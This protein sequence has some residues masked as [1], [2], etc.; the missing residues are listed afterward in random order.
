MGTGYVT[1][2]HEIA[3]PGRRAPLAVLGLALAA[4]LAYWLFATPDYVPVSDAAHYFEIAANLANGDGFAHTFPQLEL[5]ATAFR[6]P[7]YPGILAGLFVVTGSSIVAGRLLNLALG[8]VVVALVMTLGREVGGRPA[9]LAAGVA[10]AV[11]PPLVFNDLV[12]LTES[13]SLVLVLGAAL[14]LLRE[15]WVLAGVAVGLLVLSRTSA[16]VLV[17]V[18]AAW[19]FYRVGWRHAARFSLAALV[20]VAPWLVRNELQ[21]DHLGL[22]TSNGFNLAAMYSVEAQDVGA[23][24]DPVFHPGFEDL[25]LL[26]FDEAAWSEELAE[27]GLDGLRE[28]PRYIA[29][30]IGRNAAAFFE[31]KPSFNRFAEIQD[32][33]HLGV[34]GATSWLVPVVAIAGSVGLWRSRRHPG[35]QLAIIFAAYFVVVSLLTIAAP[36]LRSPADVMWCLG[37]G[38]LVAGQERISAT[39][40]SRAATKPSEAPSV[41]ASPG[42]AAND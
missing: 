28:N 5:H 23:F 2:G 37:L 21:V 40:G 20:V 12:L 9:G 6:P 7:L 11:Y 3:R 30:V 19:L 17:I 16:Q 32:G 41:S 35:A 39:S 36:R 31:V 25:R 24:V 18:L 38:L 8:L 26:Q 15:R 42:P 13:L 34:R 10:A 4:R 33:R 29:E 14:L 22:T 27:R 1:A